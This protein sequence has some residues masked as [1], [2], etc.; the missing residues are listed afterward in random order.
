MLVGLDP[1][2]VRTVAPLDRYFF[3]ESGVDW[4]RDLC[5]GPRRCRSTPRILLGSLASDDPLLLR[6]SAVRSWGPRLRAPETGCDQVG[7]AIGIQYALLGHPA[8]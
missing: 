8:P 4:Q 3:T 6:L 1:H 2:R 7:D 5:A